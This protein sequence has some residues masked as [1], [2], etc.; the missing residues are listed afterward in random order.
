[1]DDNNEGAI[2]DITSFFLMIAMLVFILIRYRK[3]KLD[4]FFKI[5]LY[6]FPLSY[7]LLAIGG[8]FHLIE[9]DRSR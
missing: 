8:V 1:M 3:T 2:S 6:I 4:H 7:L 5:I 9:S